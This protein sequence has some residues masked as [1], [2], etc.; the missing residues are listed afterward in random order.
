MAR[1]AH[2]RLADHYADRVWALEQTRVG[3]SGS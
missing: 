3:R 2:R 1:D